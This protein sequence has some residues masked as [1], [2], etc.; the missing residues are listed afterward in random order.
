MSA[1]LIKLICISFIS[2]VSSKWKTISPDNEDAF[3]H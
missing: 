3:D 1:E 2:I